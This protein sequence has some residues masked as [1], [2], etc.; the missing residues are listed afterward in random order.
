MALQVIN[1]LSHSHSQFDSPPW[2]RHVS[3]SSVKSHGSSKLLVAYWL[4][5]C[6]ALACQCYKSSVSQKLPPG[7]KKLP[8]IGNLHQL[9]EAG[10]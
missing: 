8:I 2:C 1:V 9:A 3:S 5:L 7:P 4:V 10:S 6:I